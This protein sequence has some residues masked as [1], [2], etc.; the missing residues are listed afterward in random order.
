MD[1]PIPYIDPVTGELT[2][3]SNDNTACGLY[4]PIKAP[5]PNRFARRQTAKAIKHKSKQVT[6]R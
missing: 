5:T 1:S 6:K 4:L 3:L 2:V